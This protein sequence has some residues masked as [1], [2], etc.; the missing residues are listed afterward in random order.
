MHC[1]T[2]TCEPKTGIHLCVYPANAKLYGSCETCGQP[3]W[4]TE[5]S[6]WSAR[7]GWAPRSS[8]HCGCCTHPH[9]LP[10]GGHDFTLRQWKERRYA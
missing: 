8:R 10:N 5:V 2:C 6:H 9:D 4:E 3:F 1:S 7:D